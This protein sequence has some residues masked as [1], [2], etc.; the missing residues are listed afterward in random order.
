MTLLLAPNETNDSLSQLSILFQYSLC[1]GLFQCLCLPLTSTK[2]PFH[3]RFY[4]ASY[5]L[6][7]PMLMVMIPCAFYSVYHLS[8]DL[9]NRWGGTTATSYLFCR[10]YIAINVLGT[11]GELLTW[12]AEGGTVLSKLP[13][14][15]HHILSVGAYTLGMT[16]C[17]NKVHYYAC[18]LGCCE[19][20]TF[21]LTILI[22]SKFENN[23]IAQFF[24]T[25]CPSIFVINGCLLWLTYVL[26][27]LLLFPYT[28][29][30]WIVDLQQFETL[31]IVNETP[32]IV[33]YVLPAVTI[34]LFVVSILWFSRIHAGMVKLFKSGGTGMENDTN[35]DGT[36]KD[37]E[38]ATKGTEGGKKQE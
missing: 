33:L 34:F 10:I 35:N 20:T 17:N 36:S 16:Y 12:Q 21:H 28:M 29:Y 27:R 8:T 38:A 31:Q 15:L 11:I 6:W 9:S 2:L 26:F 25:H 13:V 24:N 22:W 1:F 18:L 4:R 7:F 19:V 5:F 32:T 23:T 30:A 14:L 37:K 3:K